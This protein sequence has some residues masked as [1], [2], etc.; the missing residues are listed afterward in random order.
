MA[1]VA[2]VEHPQ[3]VVEHPHHEDEE[4]AEWEHAT[5]RYFD[6]D[7]GTPLD[8]EQVRVSSELVN[9]ATVQEGEKCGQR[10]GV[11]GGKVKFR[12]GT[13]PGVHAS[14]SGPGTARILLTLSAIFSLF[15]AT[16]D[17]SVA[18]MRTPMTE[19]V[20]VEP[21]NGGKPALRNGLAATAS[22]QRIAL[23][24]GL[25]GPTSIAC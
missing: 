6:E 5:K 21:S 22:T 3:R 16:A 15:A 12:E 25:S 23:R 8:P 4:D 11:T 17:F 14:T 24:G 1:D 9:R 13:G 7:D 10:G 19:E 20:F 18:F 2:V